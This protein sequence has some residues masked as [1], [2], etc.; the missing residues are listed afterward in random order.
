[1]NPLP[2]MP[3]PERASSAALPHALGRAGP[4]L[5]GGGDERGQPAHGRK[6]VRWPVS[7]VLYAVRRG[8]HSSGMPVARHLV[9]PTRTAMRKRIRRS[10]RLPSLF[11]FAPDGVYHAAAVAG[12]AVRSYRTLSPLPC[13][14]KASQGGLLSVALSLGSPPPGVTRHPVSV[15]PGLSSALVLTSGQRPPGHLTPCSYVHKVIRSRCRAVRRAC[16]RGQ[17]TR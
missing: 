4:P 13:F 10:S 5:G 9:Q 11:G 16:H 15:E 6:S 7:R 14:A 8:G 2:V 17:K 3:A 1:M 12:S